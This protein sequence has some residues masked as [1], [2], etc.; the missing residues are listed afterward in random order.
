MLLTCRRAS[1]RGNAAP[2]CIIGAAAAFFALVLF[3]PAPARAA[4]FEVL[5]DNNARRN[6][7]DAVDFE[8]VCN[9]RMKG[10]IVAGDVDR[11]KKVNEYF[12]QEAAGAETAAEPGKRGLCLN[13]PGGDLDAALKL[14]DETRGWTTIIEDGASCVSACALVF[15]AGGRHDDKRGRKAKT[16]GRHLHIGGKLGFHAPDIVPS[17]DAASKSYSADELR[18]KYAL[19]LK[20]VRSVV[21]HDRFEETEAPGLPPHKN[22]VGEIIESSLVGRAINDD[23]LTEDLLLIWLTT[24]PE[25]V[26]YLTTMQEAL[27]WGIELF[28]LPQ[29]KHYS[30]EML[31]IAC[32]NTASLRCLGED[33]RPDPGNCLGR[34][35]AVIDGRGDVDWASVEK[36]L[37]DQ[38]GGLHAQNLTPAGTTQQ[39]RVVSFQ[40]GDRK[41]PRRDFDELKW[42]SAC[43]VRMIELDGKV[44]SLEVATFNGRGSTD[45]LDAKLSDPVDADFVRNALFDKTYFTAGF[46]RAAQTRTWKMVP[47]KTKLADMAQLWGALEGQGDAFKLLPSPGPVTAIATPPVPAA[48]KTATPKTVVPGS[49]APAAKAANAGKGATPSAA[50][51]VVASAVKFTRLANTDMAGGDLRTL[52]QVS[53]GECESACAGDA[54]CIGYAHDDWNHWCFLKKATAT[55]SLDPASSVG[56]R[57][58]QAQP[59]RSSAPV[60]FQ[61]FRGKTFPVEQASWKLNLDFAKCEARCQEMDTCVA[62]TQVKTTN[63]CNLMTYSTGVYTTDKSADSGVKRQGGGG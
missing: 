12:I 29:P 1:A 53:F 19:A 35:R 17:E 52:P 47:Q 18:Q 48:P 3:V 32:V 15:M 34:R 24:P 7:I 51:P 25:R 54:Q 38:F 13:S 27:H 5:E 36:R 8:P 50:T 31:T 43:E 61:Y 33:G 20:T 39:L 9:V 58:G 22:E 37:V 42:R 2:G 16:A 46:L 59:A 40:I 10:Q 26:Y 11:M 55:L 30:K 4:K 56:L 60:R 6:N 57:V 63:V 49:A 28:G 14:L 62:F 23:I 44:K 21:F 45:L 41:R